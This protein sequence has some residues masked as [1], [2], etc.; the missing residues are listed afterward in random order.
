DRLVGEL[1]GLSAIPVEPIRLE[2]LSVLPAQL[3]E[4][5]VEGVRPLAKERS[6][7]LEA[8]LDPA[9]PALM[10]D[11]SRL[12]EVLAILLSNAFKSTPDGGSIQVKLEPEGA[13]ARI[14]VIDSGRGF[15]PGR[16]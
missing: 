8:V 5:A 12:E 10:A 9:V 6:I 4:A 14:Q 15:E 7:R 16:L 3:I 2:L 1:I 11:A 13:G